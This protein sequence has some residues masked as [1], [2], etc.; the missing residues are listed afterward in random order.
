MALGTLKK[1][2]GPAYLA[3]A[4]ADIY[5]PPASTIYTVIRQI[6]IANKTAGAVTFSL[7]VGAT[8]G[9]AGGTELFGA[10]SV[11]ANDVYD[12]YAAPSGLKLT[13]TEF[14]TGLASAATSL[15]ITV[16]GEQAVV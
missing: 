13:S 7:Y 14:L 10:K 3:N 12:W 1:I 8:G 9:S 2:A 11:A 16:M 15:T 6:H 5:T 4:A